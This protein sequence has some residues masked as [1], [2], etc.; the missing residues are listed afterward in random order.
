M[1]RNAISAITMLATKI[2]NRIKPVT[3]SPVPET[4]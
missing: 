2:A 4:R 1:E 3:A